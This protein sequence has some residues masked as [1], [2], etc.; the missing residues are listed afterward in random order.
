[1][2]NPKIFIS[3]TCYDL[4][5][6]RSQLRGFVSIF[7]Y[8]PVMSDYADILYDPRSHTHTSCLKEVENCDMLI[9][10]I[11]S[12]FG[13]KAIPT[14]FEE[15]NFEVLKELSSGQAVFEEKESMSITQLEV[16]KAI[17]NEI[18]IFT[19]IDSSVNH[20]HLV[21]EKNKDKEI[22]NSIIFPSIDKPETAN[23][24][25]EFI[26]FLRLRNE[27][28]NITPFSR[29]EDIES[30][31]RKQWSGLFQRLLAEQRNK[32]LDEKRMDYLSN[33]I[34]DIKTAIMTSISSSDLKETAKGAI[35]YRRM[36]DFLYQ[37]SFRKHELLIKDITWKEL[38]KAINVKEI[39]DGTNRFTHIILDNDTFFEARVSIRLVDDF[40]RQWEEFSHL[41]INSKQAIVNAILDDPVPTFR[42]VKHVD[43]PY[44][45][46]Y[47]ED[48]QLIVD[49]E[50][51]TTS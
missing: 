9:L 23:Y 30:Y 26:N 37:I 51:E 4:N 16:L 18:P 11:G 28:N 29:M 14:A 17:E 48:K 19:F 49:I 45:E 2:A 21:Y 1:M 5:V 47:S 42:I 13:G 46:V 3:S 40:S 36:I 15:L 8:E 33:Q 12:R 22:I 20:D 10:I 31:L 43:E 24:I 44:K 27:N 41:H 7:G 39:L 6:V 32:Q 34:A 25:F 35:K 38:L 50:V